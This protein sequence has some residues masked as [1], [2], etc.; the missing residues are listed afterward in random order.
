MSRDARG[1]PVRRDDAVIWWGRLPGQKA[2]LH[3]G[4]VEGFGL[5]GGAKIV[6]ALYGTDGEWRTTGVVVSVKTEKLIVVEDVPE[7]PYE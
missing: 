6:L 5:F 4:L 1:V 3:L 7:S 2:A